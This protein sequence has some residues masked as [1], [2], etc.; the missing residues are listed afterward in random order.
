MK[1]KTLAGVD[2]VGRGALFGPVVAAAVIVP[3][4]LIPTLRKLGVE[5]SKQ[6]SA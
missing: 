3:V 2:E 1:V 5:D 4:S 6:L